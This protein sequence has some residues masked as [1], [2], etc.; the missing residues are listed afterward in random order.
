MNRL[1]NWVF[2][3]QEPGW[4]TPKPAT[5]PLPRPVN[6]MT[7]IVGIICKQIII[8]GSESQYSSVGGGVKWLNQQKIEAITFSDHNQA[9]VALAGA[10]QPALR[11]IQTMKNAAA[12]KP[13]E[14]ETT[15]I[16]VAREAIKK[17]RSE[18]LEFYNQKPDLAV[19]E[20]DNIF[21]EDDKCFELLI[22]HYCPN[23]ARKKGSS[24]F[25]AD[26]FH[27]NFTV[28]GLLAILTDDCITIPDATTSIESL[29]ELL[30]GNSL[31]RA[32]TG[33]SEPEWESLGVDER[34]RRNR[35]YLERTCPLE[36]P[37]IRNEPCL[38]KI[39][40]LSGD[41]ERIRDYAL[42]GSGS[43]LAEFML[44][45]FDCRDIEEF[46]GIPLVVDALERIKSSDLYCGGKI[47]IAALGPEYFGHEQVC[48]LPDDLLAQIIQELEAL[49]KE[50]SQWHKNKFADVIERIRKEEWKK[51]LEQAKAQR[52]AAANARQNG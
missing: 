3:C 42:I 33:N 2:R 43:Q 5:E 30:R 21:S 16:S 25:L 37:K 8:I 22:A 32:F 28:G 17:Y 48:F 50:V 46:G 10:V 15:V 44:D 9:L 24:D 19:S 31:S 47:K 36:C 49:Q 40:V 14:D 45:Q 29:N 4:K 35:Q 41:A 38:Y 34:M 51:R 13:L 7:Q 23:S 27:D 1:D 18:V 12:G 20:Q 52:E 6:P 39:N 11:V 26:E